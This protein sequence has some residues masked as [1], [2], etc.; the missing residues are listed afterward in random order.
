MIEKDGSLYTPS[1]SLKNLIR[2]ILEPN[3]A[4]RISCSQ[5]LQ[6]PWLNEQQNKMTIAADKSVNPE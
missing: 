3:A 2:K 1:N 5:I 4:L 6:E